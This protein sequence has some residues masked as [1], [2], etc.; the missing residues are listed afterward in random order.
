M[1]EFEIEVALETA[2]DRLP[3]K[4]DFN[5]LIIYATNKKDEVVYLDMRGDI[6]GSEIASQDIRLAG[7]RQFGG[8]EVNALYDEYMVDPK[9]ATEKIVSKMKEKFSGNKH[10]MNLVD[11][12]SAKASDNDPSLPDPEKDPGSGM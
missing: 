6:F 12:L 1:T 2:K 3:K 7:L 4:T 8:P 9:G 10:I 11:Q 5:T